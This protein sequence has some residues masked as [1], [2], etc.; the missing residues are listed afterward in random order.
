M[1]ALVVDFDVEAGGAVAAFLRGEGFQVLQAADGQTGLEI[2]LNERPDVVITE[3]ILPKLHGLELCGKINQDPHPVPVIILTGT[4]KDQAFR[5]EATRTFG[6]SIYL[7]K[8][9]AEDKLRTALRRVLRPVMPSGKDQELE[10]VLDVLSPVPFPAAKP[11]PAAPPMAKAPPI[12]SQVV[13]AKAAAP[14]VHP[15]AP[16]PASAAKRMTS[17]DVDNLLNDALAEFGIGTKAKAPSPKPVEKLHRPEPIKAAPQPVPV[18]AEPI[19][20]SP[21]PLEVPRPAPIKVEASRPAPVKAEPTRSFSHTWPVANKS[22]PFKPM[23]MSSFAPVPVPKPAPPIASMDRAVRI[24][25]LMGN[26]N[27]P[28][29]GAA[30]QDSPE[31]ETIPIAPAGF[32]AFHEDQARKPWAKWVGIAAGLLLVVS[33]LAFVFGAK[34]SPAPGTETPIQNIEQAP[35]QNTQNRQIEDASL[36]QPEKTVIEPAANP[37]AKPVPPQV[38]TESPA[39]QAADE[40]AK[41]EANAAAEAMKP[42]SVTQVPNPGLQ[43]PEAKPVVDPPAEKNVEA[44]APLTVVERKAANLGDLVALTEVDSVPQLVKSPDPAYPPMARSR[45]L[46]GTVMMTALISETGDVLQAQLIKGPGDGMGFEAAAQKALLQWKYRPA[47]KDGVSVR[48]WKP[49]TI[50]F[51]LPPR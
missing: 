4:Y 20:A 9:F 24:E 19:K 26:E 6:A 44:E 7:E 15:S 27:H 38:K 41:V 37:A 32:D 36:V 2:F 45:R 21:Q 48:V 28:H 30:P 14:P 10:S 46:E 13:P 43:V 35:A 18:K 34:K 51:K 8:P 49:V 17:D 1:K 39:L 31:E 22:E 5:A 47:Q 23:P 16:V 33:A 29:T 42:L 11:V 40:Q 50:A 3:A 12:V 25:E